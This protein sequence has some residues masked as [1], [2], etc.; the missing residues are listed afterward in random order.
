MAL[1]GIPV[2]EMKRVGVDPTIA[3]FATRHGGDIAGI[4]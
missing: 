3:G 2:G 1:L 4:M